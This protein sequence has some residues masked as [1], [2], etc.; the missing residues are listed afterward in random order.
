M[1]AST[2]FSKMF[3]KNTKNE[4]TNR[5]CD[6]NVIPIFFSY[7]TDAQTPQ[8]S[9]IELLNLLKD[10]LK[11]CRMLFS[12]FSENN[13]QS[14]YI[15]LIDLYLN[16]TTTVDLQK[17]ITV[18]IQ[19]IRGSIEISK[20][21]MDYIYQK[22]AYLYRNSS[23]LTVNKINRLL[24]ILNSVLGDTD[25][26]EKPKNYFCFNGKGGIEV[27]LSKIPPLTP[28]HPMSIVLN[29]KICMPDPDHSAV[30]ESDYLANIIEITFSD[31]KKFSVDLKYPM[32]IIV[33]SL[34]K[35]PIKCPP[36][37]EWLALVLNIHYRDNKFFFQI[38]LNGE[39]SSI[40]YEVPNFTL[41]ENAIVESITMFNGFIGEV[42]SMFLISS[43]YANDYKKLTILKSSYLQQFRNLKEGLWKKSIIDSFTNSLFNLDS[44]DD[45]QQLPKRSIYV[46][47]KEEPPRKLAEDVKFFFT[48]FSYNGVT[49][50]DVFGHCQAVFTE[51][52]KV[53]I[54]RA[55]QKKVSIIS[56]GITNLLP[57][58]E[59]LY[60]NQRILTEDV[61]FNYLTVINTILNDRKKNIRNAK[62]TKF[63]ETLSLFIE[64][65]PAK[66]FTEQI[67]EALASI[68]R[69]AFKE[70][71]EMLASVYFKH[72]FLNEKILSK[73][74]QELQ[75]K[76]WNT[77]ALFC[78]SDSS[79]LQ[80]FVNMKKICL[81]LQSYDEKKYSQMCC[82][83]HY[84]QFNH[85]IVGKL[86]I[87]QPSMNQKLMDLKGIISLIIDSQ[88]TEN[89]IVLFKL[90]T[91][92][93]SPCLAKFIINIFKGVFVSTSNK[94]WLKSLYNVMFGEKCDVIVINTFKHGLLDIRLDIIDLLKEMHKFSKDHQELQTPNNMGKVF[95]ML[96]SCLIPQSNFYVQD[97]T[98]ISKANE[99]RDLA[100]HCAQ[101]IRKEQ[102]NYMCSSFKGNNI[103]FKKEHYQ[104]YINTLY[105]KLL[106]WSLQREREDK[107]KKQKEPEKKFEEIKLEQKIISYY[108]VLMIVLTLTDKLN[109]PCYY[110]KCIDYLRLFTENKTNCSNIIKDKLVLFWII[111]LAFDNFNVHNSYSFN[112]Y[113]IAFP[114]L[115]NIIS[116][117]FDIFAQ[118]AQ[119]VQMK[120]PMQ[121]L[122]S[123]FLWADKIRNVNNEHRIYNFLKEILKGV[124]DKFNQLNKIEFNI[125]KDK[126]DKKS[127]NEFQ[128]D[129]Y[130]RNYL[131]LITF[132]Y[133]F[134]FY[135]KFDI[136][137]FENY[138]PYLNIKVHTMKMPE[139]LLKSISLDM[140]AGKKIEHAWSDYVFFA[141]LMNKVRFLWGKENTF[142]KAELGKS[143]L[144]KYDKLVKNII[145]DKDK[146]NLYLDDLKLLC[147]SEKEGEVEKIV[148]LIRIIPIT[149]AIIINTVRVKL[150]D[151]MQVKYWIKEM[152]HFI[153]F[154]ILA[155]TNSTLINQQDQY[156][157]LQNKS[158]DAIVFCICFLRDELDKTE[159]PGI[160]YVRKTFQ[161]ILTFCI[162]IVHAQYTYI[163]NHKSILKKL[164][165]PARN[166]L[167]HCAV[168]KLFTEF[169]TDKQGQPL[170]TL[171]LIQNSFLTQLKGVIQ[172]IINNAEWKAALFENTTLQER[173]NF[174]YL[175]SRNYQ[176]IVLARYSLLK[177]IVNEINENYQRDIVALVQAYDNEL[178]QFS[179]NSFY[180]VKTNKTSYKH[181]KKRLF[182][183]YGTWSDRTLFYTDPSKL[184]YRILNHYTKYFSR[185]CLIPILDLDYYIPDF[186]KF[187]VKT[188]FKDTHEQFKLGLDIDAML[189]M[190]T[191][192]TDKSDV[193]KFDNVNF[194][195]QIY[196]RSNPELS[197]SYFK[198]NN[199]MDLA[200]DADILS[201]LTSSRSGIASSKSTV[202]V[203]NNQPKRYLCCLVKQSHHIKG[204][205]SV[206]Q[207]NITFRVFLNQKAG[208]SLS[209][210]DIGFKQTDEDFDS[211]RKTCFGSYFVWH[212]KDLDKSSLVIDFKQINLFFRKRYYFKNSAM[213]IFT[214]HNKSYY[215]NFKE[216]SNRE[217]VI[218]EIL[219]HIKDASKL[220]DDLRDPKTPFDNVVGYQTQTK[221]KKRAK[222][223]KLSKI[224]SS[225]CNWEIS[226]YELIMWLNFFANR[227][228][229][230]LTQYPVM[231][232]VLEDYTDPLQK[233]NEEELQDYKYRD[234][235]LPM[236]MLTVF[237]E[238][239]VRKELFVDL[240]DTMKA[241]QSPG[242]EPEMKPYV[243][244]S[245]YSNPV[246]VAN[247]LTRLFP[248]SHIAIEL[249][250]AGFDKADR[251][252][253][254]IQTSFFNS[255][256]Q[257]TD[258]RELIPEFYYLPEM[259]RNLNNLNLGIKENNEHVH[260][261]LTPC[262][263]EPY[264]FVLTLRKVLESSQVS[265]NIQKWID[266]IF[267]YKQRGKEADLA[268]NVFTDKSY[269]DLV[270]VK[271]EPEKAC[272]YRLVE[273]GLT[274]EQVTAKE[275]PI[276]AK[277]ENVKKTKEIMDSEASLKTWVCLSRFDKKGETCNVIKAQIFEN[278]L[279]NLFYS[280]NYFTQIK[281]S[282]MLLGE[283]EYKADAVK[284]NYQLKNKLLYKINDFYEN[285]DMSKQPPIYFFNQ[286]KNVC[287]GGFFDGK[288]TILSIDH[289]LPIE[290]THPLDNNPITAIEV[291]KD[292]EYLICGNSIGNIYVYNISGNECVL[293]KE[294][295][296]F[297][298]AITSINLNSELNLW[299]SCSTN[300][301]VNIYTMPTCKLV[302]SIKLPDNT[303][304]NVI[305][306]SSCPLPCL[307]VICKMEMFVYTINGKLHFTQKTSNAIVSPIIMRDLHFMEYLAY[308]MDDT[309]YIRSFP[310]MV[311]EGTIQVSPN[312]AFLCVSEDM[313]VLYGISQDGN[314]IQVILEK[315]EVKAGDESNVEGMTQSMIQVN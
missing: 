192:T 221:D 107:T 76:F 174:N 127:K 57:I 16:E 163:E 5:L 88:D 233:P 8:H 260:N 309:V 106:I 22:F 69:A 118:Q 110:K 38:F 115:V 177:Q 250:G 41:E 103:I 116:G 235:S 210:V 229:L 199:K 31:Q 84:K 183:W 23:E 218:T 266:L 169:I 222:K 203:P 161:H 138:A 81:I 200:K 302:R 274:P 108:D 280:N 144:I 47:R 75:I 48:P 133:Y 17:A 195:R 113:G 248:F 196:K 189:K 98:Y 157:L 137:I 68:G 288:F 184:K 179:N 217:R 132:I 126:K 239:E 142:K 78:Q 90:L 187:N 240:Y 271:K 287:L 128:V 227:S 167:T 14:I 283:Q 160:E 37:E 111:Q 125:I 299:A 43:K 242:E 272:L 219:A 232:W 295:S 296:T 122:E 158:L 180:L 130:K 286:G 190:Y 212:H 289:A 119:N 264:E 46:K 172:A 86:D 276:R 28:R 35:D 73:F 155:S 193:S 277:K 80:T 143:A 226:N 275:F 19:E 168:F 237:P 247:Y 49:I 60:L 269:E 44:D 6:M 114:T 181:I 267:G 292:E 145:L 293:E 15:S 206:E 95:S 188:L 10:K 64:K 198:I 71:E 94:T 56:G 313:L 256:T 270:D 85:D 102:N 223:Q 220:I 191:T 300:G 273:F 297:M 153:R 27:N 173:M 134:N 11:S 259:F 204:V 79:Q 99:I 254:S 87:M 82:E 178:T 109:E 263:D 170:L 303:Q 175:S 186:T 252:F 185:P 231:P 236:G 112:I 62:D 72:I 97:R 54:F 123:L 53:H 262:N 13:G 211:E 278:N 9:K 301:Y 50:N 105:Q 279:I 238:S 243:Y 36:F 32:F 131:V 101:R 140:N 154:I 265:A 245:H 52:V 129:F 7:L 171:Q 216:E 291:D 77:I 315:K 141:D 298:G 74:S 63:F 246:Y 312:V 67:L 21:E 165:K 215:F 92:D 251:L 124:L 214:K 261:V 308:L 311:L 207:H 34:R 70:T 268:Y 224:I 241:E 55:L 306:L 148:P 305:Y 135:F 12:Y 59:M 18:F 89:A 150:K 156:H 96:K 58:A 117:N 166:D 205:L 290:V 39:N 4:L 234:L 61:L 182:S 24:L 65:F 146:K 33:K 282:S 51:G 1:E 213:E 40:S 26:S 202:V 139:Q 159:L 314:E 310:S 104:D 30:L 249:Q 194:I 3:L 294:I 151:E 176:A 121:E 304:P 29:F 93:V 281:L 45:I 197:Y 244:G 253:C 91:L 25:N 230:D 149:L 147:Y 285:E 258:L 120:L 208:N 257:K 284:S 307:V 164:A 20:H 100:M 201:S 42:T 209:G 66:I 152:R 2:I 162:Y 228:Y 136:D 255:A 83:E 225:W